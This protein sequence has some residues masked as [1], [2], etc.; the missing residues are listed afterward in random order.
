[1]NQRDQWLF[2]D[3]T[4][5]AG[6]C[7]IDRYKS[8][9]PGGQHKNKVETAIRVVHEPSGLS[10]QGQQTRSQLRNKTLA[11]R[12]LRMHIACSC[13]QPQ[14]LT[15]LTIPDEIAEYL[16]PPSDSAPQKQNKRK[17]S[18]GSGNWYFWP[19]AAVVLD[20]FDSSQGQLSTASTA[21]GISTAN[22]AAFLRG[23][24]H[25]LQAAQSIRKIHNHTPLR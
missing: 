22:L 6:D 14:D 24:R 15:K 9:G 17:L 2:C 5:L 19:V 23:D 8:R 3:L 18:M 11:L 12:N 1:M 13:R 20:V 7:R 21:L 25:L 16:Q 10:A 4:K